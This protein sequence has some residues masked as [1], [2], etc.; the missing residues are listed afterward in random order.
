MRSEP[1]PSIVVTSDGIVATS[2]RGSASPTDGI[3][4]RSS[5]LSSLSCASLRAAVS[6]MTA[7]ICS[8][9]IAAFASAKRPSSRWVI[10][11]PI[12]LSGLSSTQL[13]WPF[14]SSIRSNSPSK[15]RSPAA[16]FDLSSASD[17]SNAS[18]SIGGLSL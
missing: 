18:A 12:S 11:V 4:A 2:R 16:S 17:A 13:R 10:S 8:S 14:F 6:A 9:D 5:A 3:V 1:P 7:A 15:T